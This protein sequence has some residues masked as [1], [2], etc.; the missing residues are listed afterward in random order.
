MALLFVMCFSG[1]VKM[2]AGLK[3]WQLDGKLIINQGMGH[4]FGHEIPSGYLTG[5]SHGIDGPFID[6]FP[7]LCS[8][9][10]W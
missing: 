10:R 7:W 2:V 5:Y 9:T 8:I 1:A 4:P 6:D 3:L